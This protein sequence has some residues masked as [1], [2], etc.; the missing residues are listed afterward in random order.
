MTL[1]LTYTQTIFSHALKCSH[2]YPNHLWSCFKVVDQDR[3]LLAAN[4]FSVVRASLLPFLTL[5]PQ[6]WRHAWSPAPG[7]KREGFSVCSGKVWVY[8]E[9]SIFFSFGGLIH[10]VMFLSLFPCASFCFHMYLARI[11]FSLTFRIGV[12]LYFIILL[13]SCLNFWH[14]KFQCCN[15]S[16]LVGYRKDSAFLFFN[17]QNNL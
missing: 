17:F 13:I 7:Y 12:F 15:R 5:D 11:L 3:K 1:F 4:T 9:S 14:S 10:T 16:L 6:C 2:L 8:I